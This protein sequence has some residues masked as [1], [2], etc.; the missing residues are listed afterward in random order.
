MKD[1]EGN[2]RP[3]QFPLKVETGLGQK[4]DFRASSV[5]PNF[6]IFSFQCPLFCFIFHRARFRF[7]F[8]FNFSTL[9]S[10]YNAHARK[11]RSNQTRIPNMKQTRSRYI[12]TPNIFFLAIDFHYFGGLPYFFFFF[13]FL[14][15][16]FFPQFW[17]IYSFY[18]G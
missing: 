12:I 14:Q 7:I 18:L 15:V 8:Y 2:A 5:L 13:F 3:N 6:R 1:I 17:L 11:L 10:R 4:G 9:P 16:F